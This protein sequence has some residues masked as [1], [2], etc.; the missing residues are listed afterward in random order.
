MKAFELLKANG[1]EV[2]TIAKEYASNAKQE[3]EISIVQ[4]AREE[5]RKKKMEILSLETSISLSTDV[6]AGKKQM[7][8][9]EITGILGKVIKL[10]A[11]VAILEDQLKKYVIPAFDS[12]FKEESTTT[13]FDDHR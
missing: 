5:I 9:N 8:Y 3:L 2:K 1:A 6:N 12:Y 10:N 4:E 7:S 11:E 13:H